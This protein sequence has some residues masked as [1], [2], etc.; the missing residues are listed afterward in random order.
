MV[1]GMEDQYARKRRG[2][3]C[4]DGGMVEVG[5]EV[6]L[7]DELVTAA[8]RG[9]WDE[10]TGLVPRGSGISRQGRSAWELKRIASNQPPYYMPGRLHNRTSTL[11]VRCWWKMISRLREAGWASRVPR[12]ES[13]LECSRDHPQT[14]QTPKPDISGLPS[15]IIDQ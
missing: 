10:K 3:T 8:G 2:E 13:A 1:A 15:A 12:G 9:R 7:G 14:G 6:M 4:A 5:L 11:T